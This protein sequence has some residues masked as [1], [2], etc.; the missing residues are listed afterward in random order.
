LSS[1]SAHLEITY[2]ARAL[3]H[4]LHIFEQLSPCILPG[5]GITWAFSHPHL[6][7]S[8]SGVLSVFQRRHIQSTRAPCPQ[9]TFDPVN[10][11]LTHPFCL[12]YFRLDVYYHATS[13]THGT[14]IDRSC[15]FQGPPATA[16]VS[17]ALILPPFPQLKEAAELQ[18][19][20]HHVRE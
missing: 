16:G 8:R 13:N 20:H 5:L 1:V 9:A 17:R 12:K 11:I 4:T 2:L 14:Q 10:E 6:F 18:P 19:I 15:D 3:S 7:V